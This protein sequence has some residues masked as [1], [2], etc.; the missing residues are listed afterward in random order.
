MSEDLRVATEHLRE[1]SMR[2]GHAAGELATATA[3]VTGVD[4]S[5][6][7]THGPISSSTAGAVEAAQNA[8]RTAGLSMATLS[9]SLSEKL[10][11]AARRYDHTDEDG[12]AA[13]Q[14]HT[15]KFG[16]PAEQ[17]R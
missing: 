13:L 5:L 2:Q 9:E 15:D 1:L 16:Q 3:A 10:T 8:R 4:S 14:T 12:A 6:R 7:W 17:T 11:A